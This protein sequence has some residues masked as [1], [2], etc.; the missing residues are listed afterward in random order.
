M[1]RLL[2]FFIFV[3]LF[4][5]LAFTFTETEKF[6]GVIMKVLVTGGQGFIGGHVIHKLLARGHKVVSFDRH[7]KRQIF[8]VEN[9]T[10]Y[11]LHCS[12]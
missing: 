9:F 7:I 12:V 6:K 4:R 5:R 1:S 3:T 11:S 8:R 10:T 2:V